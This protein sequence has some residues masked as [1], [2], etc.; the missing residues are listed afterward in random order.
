R[1]GARLD[2]ANVGIGRRAG[3]LGGFGVLTPRRRNIRQT[4]GHLRRELLLFRRELFDRWSAA[5]DR[6][7]H[8]I[9]RRHRLLLVLSELTLRRVDDLLNLIDRV[10]EETV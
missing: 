8:L 4:L 9:Q 6:R 10:G 3:L 7:L 1:R 2:I 5:G